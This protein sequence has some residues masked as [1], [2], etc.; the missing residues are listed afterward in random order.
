MA[1]TPSVQLRRL[2]NEPDTT[3][4]SDAEILQRLLDAGDDLNVAAA[5]IWHEKMALYSDMVDTSEGGSS[6]K[7]DQAWQHAKEMYELFTSLV[8]AAGGRTV[9]RRITRV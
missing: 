3:T 2:V 9:L 5:A 4:Y 7:M 8:D 6:R 1:L